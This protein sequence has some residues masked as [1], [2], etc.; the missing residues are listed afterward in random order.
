[1]FTASHIDDTTRDLACTLTAT[2]TFG[3]ALEMVLRLL[4]LLLVSRSELENIFQQFSARVSFSVG[5]S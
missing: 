3:M 5:V 4:V 2:T 1:M